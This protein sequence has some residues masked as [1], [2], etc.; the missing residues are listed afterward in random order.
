M[1]AHIITIG[2]EILI[3]QIIDTNASFIAQQLDRIGIEVSQILSISDTNSEILETLEY[4]NGKADIVLITG[5]LGPTR[6]DLTKQAFCDYFDD[7]LVTDQKVLHHIED[8]FKNQIKRPI[9]EANKSQALV[10]AK[11]HVLPNRYGTA[12]GLW[13]E[14]N[15][16]AFIA[17]PGVPYEMKALMTDVIIPRLQKVYE[18]P[19]IIHKTIQTYGVGESEIAALLEDWENALPTHIKLAYLPDPGRVR[20]RLSTRGVD[21]QGLRKDLEE[22]T[23]SLE[24][25]L[26]DIILGYDDSEPLEALL[27][28]TFTKNNASLAL[29]ESCTGGQIAVTLTSIPGTSAFFK[30]GVVTYATKSKVDVLGVSEKIIEKHSV[31]SADVAIE[32]ARRAQNLYKADYAVSTTG[33]AGPEK[34]DS[35]AEVGTVFIGIATPERVFAEKFMMGKHRERV[36][37]K[38]VNKAMELLQKEVM[39]NGV[40][41]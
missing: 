20:L 13:M 2:D 33:N 23:Q 26:G 25:L 5:G 9:L 32:M 18:R 34:G 16:T 41:S 27:C 40:L 28:H 35:D 4:A 24:K 8:L 6:D 19:Y 10:P 21:L 12:P 37:T 39:K 7:H 22:Q 38:T 14:R 11:A 3:G 1:R 31:V 17:M 29:A 36:I 30:G 15:K